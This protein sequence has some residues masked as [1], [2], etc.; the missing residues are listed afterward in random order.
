MFDWVIAAN[1]PAAPENHDGPEPV[2]GAAPAFVPDVAVPGPPAIP[3][4]APAAAPVPRGR[5][6]GRGGRGRGR[7]PGGGLGPGWTAESRL[8]GK[9]TR[10]EAQKRKAVEVVRELQGAAAPAL[11]RQTSLVVFGGH[12]L[13]TAST[14]VVPGQTLSWIRSTCRKRNDVYLLM[15]RG[16]VSHIDSQEG[17]TLVFRGRSTDRHAC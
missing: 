5:A 11:D 7:P 3:P 9:A 13:Q 4:P 12:D 17:H 1:A 16:V 15:D 14:I 2:V 8:A 6:R 10:A